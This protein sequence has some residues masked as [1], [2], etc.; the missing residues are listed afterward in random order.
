MLGVIDICDFRYEVNIIVTLSK[1][2]THFAWGKM[3]KFRIKIYYICYDYYE[4]EP[5]KYY[6]TWKLT[7][8]N[9]TILIL[10]ILYEFSSGKFDSFTDFGW[11]LCELSATK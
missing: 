7:I 1:T 9:G 5:C 4:V 2:V 3:W 11:L 10:I 8:G 6:G